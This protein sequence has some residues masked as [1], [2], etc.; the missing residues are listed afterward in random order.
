MATIYIITYPQLVEM[1]Q[2]GIFIKFLNDKEKDLVKEVKQVPAPDLEALKS[3]LTTMANVVRISP[4]RIHGMDCF[5]IAL[6]EKSK[7]EEVTTLLTHSGIRFFVMRQSKEI[8]VC[9]RRSVEAFRLAIQDFFTNNACT[10]PAFS[11]PLYISYVKV[12]PTPLSDEN[13]LSKTAATLRFTELSSP[14]VSIWDLNVVL[15]T[16]FRVSICVH[17]GIGK[18][19]I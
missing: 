17:N 6:N 14:S 1:A 9:E 12:A 11:L 5:K 16:V 3:A 10:I 7:L 19:N 4:S 18:M 15:Y 8:W 2:R 13:S